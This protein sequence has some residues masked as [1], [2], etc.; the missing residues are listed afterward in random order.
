MSEY[1]YRLWKRYGRVEEHM[2]KEKEKVKKPRR[3]KKRFIFLNL[4]LVVFILAS[5][6][7]VDYV[8]DRYEMHTHIYPTAD[9]TVNDVIMACSKDDIVILNDFHV[10]KDGQLIL[11]LESDES[12]DVDADFT[13]KTNGEDITFKSQFTVNVMG[14]IIEHRDGSIN[15]NGYLFLTYAFLGVMAITLIVMIGS[16]VECIRKNNYSYKMVAYGGVSLYIFVLLAVV[17][18]K[19]LN[20]VLN[21]FTDLVFLITQTGR[22][23]CILMF[24]PMLI[25]A[26]AVT[27]SNIVLIKRE[28]FR[29]VNMIGIIISLVWLVVLLFTLNIGP[30]GTLFY[31]STTLSA[32]RYILSFVI[33]YF[34]CMFVS[35]VVC[36]S[37]AA[38]HTPSFDRD[39]IVILGC[40][41]RKDGGLTPLLKGRVD[42]AL[43]FAKRQ[44]KTTGKQ[45]TFVP[46][47]GQ[48]S[49]DIMSEAEA[50]ANYLKEQGVEPERILKED[51][52]TNTKENL[53]FAREVI[54][55]TTDDFENK[56]IAF[57][58]TN[59]HVFRGYVLSL[60]NGFKAEGISAKTK[61]YFFPNAFLREF[62]GLLNEEKVRHVGIILFIVLIAIGILFVR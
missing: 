29:P 15:F 14:T 57:S 24:I 58:T 40:A 8:G 43:S 53:K 61:W 42:S 16:F 52:S 17:I 23:L 32:I 62:L 28:G 21:S 2:R 41:I 7:Y 35:I 38:N 60:K 1:A 19:M 54:E 37:M 49:D 56:K 13:V 50:M 31:G 3:F 59:Y 6:A 55:K 33:A 27:I 30:F 39:Y 9:T 34:E 18:Y 47:G 46:A 20:N 25:L 45:A 26:I 44:Q 10:D 51:Q 5:L 11:D 48:G 22:W 12:G 36:A 4:M